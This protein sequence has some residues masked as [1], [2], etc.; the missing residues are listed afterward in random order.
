[1]KVGEITVKLNLDT[2]EFEKDLERLQNII[3]E[4]KELIELSIKVGEVFRMV[5]KDDTTENAIR[6]LNV[7]LQSHKV[8]D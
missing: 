6:G 4:N 7:S 8:G 2:T 3:K 5:T 1:M